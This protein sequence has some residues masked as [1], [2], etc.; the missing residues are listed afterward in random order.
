MIIGIGTK[1]T[2]I[3]KPKGLTGTLTP[4]AE[5]FNIELEDGSGFIGLET[6]TNPLNTNLLLQEAAP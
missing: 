1:L 2:D 4:P 3:R 6:Q 5:P